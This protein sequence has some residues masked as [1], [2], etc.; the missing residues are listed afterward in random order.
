MEFEAKTLITIRD[1]EYTVCDHPQVP[2]MPYGQEGRAGTVYQIKQNDNNS[3]WALKIFKPRF[4]KPGLVRQ[5][6]QILPYSQYPGLKACERVVLNT[7]MD[8]TLLKQYPDLLYAVLMPWITGT[9][10][11]DILLSK[12]NWGA[13][14]VL[15]S[16]KAL[17]QMMVKMEENGM[18]HGDLAAGNIIFSVNGEPQLIDLEG[19]FAPGFTKPEPM[20]GGSPGYAHRTAPQGLWQPE[21]DRFAGAIMISEILG[22]VSINISEGCWGESYFNQEELQKDC[23]RY[24]LLYSELKH[25]WGEGIAR[26]LER[27]W[28]SG[29]VEECPTFADWLI[30]LPTEILTVP[31]K[32]VGIGPKTKSVDETLSKQD[33]NDPSPTTD[34]DDGTS[35]ATN[36]GGAVIELVHAAKARTEHG[37]YS[38]ALDLYKAALA[39]PGIHAGQKKEIMALV[40][41]LHPG[42][43]GEETATPLIV[44]DRENIQLQKKVIPVWIRIGGGLLALVVIVLVVVLLILPRDRTDDLGSQIGQPT[45]GGQPSIVET[46]MVTEPL[47]SDTDNEITASTTPLPSWTEPTVNVSPT[48]QPFSTRADSEPFGR[49]V[50]SCTIDGREQICIIN[51]DGTG[52]QQ[53]T[54]SW[55]GNNGYPTLAPDGVTVLYNSDET[56][57]N[58]IYTYDLRS[59]ITG[60]LTNSAGHSKQPDVSPDGRQVAFT[61]EDPNTGIDSIWTMSINGGSLKKVVSEGWFPVW[62]PDGTKILF[63]AG[64]IDRPQLYI[65]SQNSGAVTKITNMNDIGGRSDWSVNGL[66]ASNIGASGEKRI[67]VIDSNGNNYQI[68]TRSSSTSAPTFSPN[69]Q[70]IAFTG[71]YDDPGLKNCDIY[72]IRVDGSDLRRLTTNSFCDWQPRW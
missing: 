64:N 30:A 49:I 28:H 70:W 26:L 69:G 71:Y 19:L 29:T 35:Q 18:A 24:Q 2:G 54:F 48:A 21:A 11:Q 23:E 38:G 15:R 63:A 41:D 44:T 9:T 52:F 27:A 62:S 8:A 10:W 7:S 14:T 57:I 66:I 47:A 43:A 12:I 31:Q 4:R 1:R 5:S 61:Y 25:M 13:R 72:L 68:L 53:L 65:Y 59:N 40:H 55:E 46:S 36:T 20:T 45:K 42:S 34:G 51:A 60:Q 37:D 56:G 33:G 39:L 50:F 67:F 58:Q 3:L 32:R 6:S 16:A 17:I 22:W